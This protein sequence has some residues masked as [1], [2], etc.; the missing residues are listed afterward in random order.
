MVSFAMPCLNTI[1][2]IFGSDIHL[3]IPPPPPAPAV[4]VPHA[5]VWFVGLSQKANFLLKAVN[6]S[7]AVSRESDI[8][9]PVFA[10]GGNVV[11]RGHDSGPHPV[12]IFANALLPLILIGSSSKA[13]FASGTV[14]TKQGHLAV[15]ACCAANPQLQC[16]VIPLPSGVAITTAST[17]KA[18]LTGKD[19]GN[20]IAHMVFD[21]AVTVAI[22]RAIVWGI[23][24]I[25]KLA[26]MVKLD[27]F[28]KWI[29]R[30]AGRSDKAALELARRA[31]T[32][33]KW[34]VWWVLRPAWGLDFLHSRDRVLDSTRKY[35]K[36]PDASADLIE[37]SLGY[38]LGSPMGSSSPFA[39][40]PSNLSNAVVDSLFYDY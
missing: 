9:K 29:V 11:G 31:R 33:T 2:P 36:S 37:T 40:F 27:A 1:Q 39:P 14:M 6:T 4:P 5:V 35:L 22:G 3:S 25:G 10:C 15:S 28:A 16:G 13:E 34:K 12:H 26:S 23:P 24:R 8:E 30:V 20:G 21:S 32:T 19:I 17:V 18:S 38:L 7:K